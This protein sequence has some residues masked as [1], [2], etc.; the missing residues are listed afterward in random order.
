MKLRI[1]NV[2]SHPSFHIGGGN[3]GPGGT[4][5]PGQQTG[6]GARGGTVTALNVTK[7]TDEKGEN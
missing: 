5:P 2:P 4:C 7:D 6:G 3:G 1:N